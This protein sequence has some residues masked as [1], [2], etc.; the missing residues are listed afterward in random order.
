M[1]DSYCNSE[2]VL[3]ISFWSANYDLYDDEIIYAFY[4]QQH[5]QKHEGLT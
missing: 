3:F 5:E 4:V 1:P 2:R